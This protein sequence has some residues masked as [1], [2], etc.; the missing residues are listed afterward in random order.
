MKQKII[1]RIKAKFPGVNLSVKRLDEI[2]AKLEAKITDENEIDAK[3]DDVNDVTPFADMAKQ[4]DRIRDLEVKAKKT[5]IKKPET[6][7]VDENEPGAAKVDNGEE[8][9]A[10]AKPLMATV[11]QL[12]T[13]NVQ[14]SMRTKLK[15]QLKDVPETFYQRWTLPEK[16][17][18]LAAF[19][20]NVKADYSTFKQESNNNSFANNTHRPAGGN[21]SMTTTTEVVP[22]EV[23]DDVKNWSSK[24]QP[25]DTT[26]KA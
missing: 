21:G 25:V 10:W 16:E 20:E 6:T 22:K 5:G 3:L 18:D 7:D 12:A 2:S 23:I 15:E 26:K 1:A 11:Q 4:D 9:P 17:E 8:I 13:G 19:V 14:A 24:N